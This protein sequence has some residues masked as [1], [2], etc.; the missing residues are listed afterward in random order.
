M[1]PPKE[2]LTPLYQVCAH[3][4]WGDGGASR[5]TLQKKKLVLMSLLRGCRCPLSRMPPIPLLCGCAKPFASHLHVVQVEQDRVLVC[6]RYIEVKVNERVQQTA[7]SRQRQTAVQ[8]I[9]VL[10]ALWIWRAGACI[11]LVEV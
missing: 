4:P 3:K 9:H 6:T 8:S 2:T 1:E 11:L 7:V 10:P 5:R